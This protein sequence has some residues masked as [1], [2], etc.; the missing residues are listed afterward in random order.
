MRNSRK[1]GPPPPRTAGSARRT[2]S[3]QAVHV[4]PVHRP[5]GNFVTRRLQ[6]QIGFR[7]GAFERGAHRIE[8]VLAAKQHRQL[9]QRGQI[10]AF[11]ELPFGHGA[12]AEEAC[13]DARA[14]APS[15]RPAPGRRQAAIRRR[16]SRCRRKSAW[17][18]RTDASSRHARGCILPACRTSPPSRPWLERRAPAPGRVRDRSPRLRRR[19]RVPV[20]RR[21]QSLPR[22]YTDAR[23]R[24]FCRPY[25]VPRT[26]LRSGGSGT[27]GA[28]LQ[29]SARAPD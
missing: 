7:L 17:R 28:G 11:V 15:C 1:S 22:R 8:V 2:A 4:H 3:S 9:P 26:S 13:R 24:G 18:R 14:A 21:Q 6:A 29:G 20:S 19:A 25:R 12:F 16:R 23:S 27:S 10:E 5:G